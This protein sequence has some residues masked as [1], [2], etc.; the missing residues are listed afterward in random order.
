MEYNVESI[1]PVERKVTVTVP[2]EE[3][4][5]AILATTALYRRDADMKGFR[6]GKVPSSIVESK[7]KKQI[8][9]EATTDMVNLHINEVL[10]ELKLV[11]LS[12]LN[13]DSG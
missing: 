5:A 13:V 1:S 8:I 10:G 4:D 6:K 11:P 3:V 9:D 7:Y 2:A 12:G